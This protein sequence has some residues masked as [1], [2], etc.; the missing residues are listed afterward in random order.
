M[1]LKTVDVKQRAS[2]R[3]PPMHVMPPTKHRHDGMDIS[4]ASSGRVRFNLRAN[5]TSAK[6]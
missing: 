3:G 1:A 5:G 4:G 2:N 6:P